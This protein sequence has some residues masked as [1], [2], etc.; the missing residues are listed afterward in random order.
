MAS[1]IPGAGLALT[2]TGLKATVEQ[3]RV[4]LPTVWALLGVETAGCG[5]LSDGGRPVVLQHDQRL[6]LRHTEVNLPPVR[7]HRRLHH[8]DKVLLRGKHLR[9]NILFHRHARTSLAQG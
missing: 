7:G 1:I 6:E 9:Y 2:A 4:D 8:P 5:Y 3:L